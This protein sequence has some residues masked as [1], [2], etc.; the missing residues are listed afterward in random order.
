MRY[1]LLDSN[2]IVI[3]TQP[4][5]Q[6][7]FIPCPDNVMAGYSYDPVGNVFSPPPPPPL[8]RWN[9]EDRLR[10]RLQAIQQAK[11]QALLNAALA[12]SPNYPN[13]PSSV[14]DFDTILDGMTLP[15]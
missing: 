10:V 7:G 3:Q 6:E 13:L 4:N 9:F 5:F 15:D 14:E 1:A 12:L 8:E 2:N 11:V